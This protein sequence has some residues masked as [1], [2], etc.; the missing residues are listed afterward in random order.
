MLNKIRELI[1]L[2]HRPIQ[3]FLACLWLLYGITLFFH[4]APIVEHPIFKSFTMPPALE[5][6]ILVGI[7]IIGFIGLFKKTPKL[8]FVFASFS[9]YKN[10]VGALSIFLVTGFAHSWW[11]NEVVQSAAS[12]L[13]LNKTIINFQVLKYIKQIF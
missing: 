8:D 1:Y 13:L 9:L 11:V 12:V 7:S 2:D 4:E 6:L 10:V 3:G 5:A